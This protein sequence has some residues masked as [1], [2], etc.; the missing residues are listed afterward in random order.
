MSRI[1]SVSWNSW[2]SAASRLSLDIPPRERILTSRMTI[3]PSQPEYSVCPPEVLAWRKISGTWQKVFGSF[4]REGVSVEWHDF[5]VSES[6]DWSKSFHEDSLEIC[7][8]LKGASR[9]CRKSQSVELKECSIGIYTTLG[10]T[11][12]ADRKPGERHQFATIEISREFLQRT[13]P[14]DREQLQPAV[15][16]FLENKAAHGSPA[17]ILPMSVAQQTLSGLFHQPPVTAPAQPLWYQAK[18]FEVMAQVLFIEEKEMFC[19]RQKRVSGERVSKVKEILLRDLG[20]PPSLEEIGREVGCSSFYLSRTFA[21]ETGMTIPQ[22]LRKIRMERAAEL[23]LTGR[24][25][26]TEVALEVGYSSLSHFSRIFCETTGYCPALYPSM[27]LP[28]APAPRK[29]DRK[30]LAS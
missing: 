15:R 1:A 22:F 24:Y 21:Q 12:H 13:L 11:L 14:A 25:N 30:S 23:L 19:T 9:L 20:A 17:V 27:M 28:K 5:E 6:L 29:S 3:A 2:N 16:D 26:V 8:N 4:G 10:E 18:V 7:L